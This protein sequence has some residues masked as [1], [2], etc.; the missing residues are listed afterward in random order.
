MRNEKEATV[1]TTETL[2]AMR[3]YHKQ[4]YTNKMDNLEEMEKSQEDAVS[5]N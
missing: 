4:R 2:R 1:D 5:Q 3:D